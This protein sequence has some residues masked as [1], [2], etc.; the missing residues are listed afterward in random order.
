[1]PSVETPQVHGVDDWAR[2]KGQR[3]GTVP[4]DLEK[5]QPVDLL[6]DRTADVLFRHSDDLDQDELAYRDEVAVRNAAAECSKRYL[7]DILDISSALVVVVVGKHDSNVACRLLHPNDGTP[8]WTPGDGREVDFLF[9]PHP[10]AFGPKSLH[11]SVRDELPHVHK[12]F[13][14]RTWFLGKKRNLVATERR[15]WILAPG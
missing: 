12:G 11:D 1:M 6:A 15:T 9:V 3:Y 5:R 14:N 13:R 10:A 8:I 4:V 2:R 7:K